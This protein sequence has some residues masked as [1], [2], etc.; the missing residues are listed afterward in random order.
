[1]FASLQEADQTAL[2]RRLGYLHLMNPLKPEFCRMQCNLNVHEQRRTVEFLVQ[3]AAIETGGRVFAL[4]NGK[5]VGLPASWADKGVP[6]TALDAV[7][8]YDAMDASYVSRASRVALAEQYT[9][10]FYGT[11]GK[12]TG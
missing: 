7:M 4:T 8:I 1:M 10:G 5:Q 11:P 9:V 3:L 12:S 6:S 2:L